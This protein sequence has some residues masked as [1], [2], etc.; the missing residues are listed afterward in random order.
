MATQETFSTVEIDFLVLA[1]R[2]QFVK[3]RMFDRSVLFW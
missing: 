2:P 3:M 1:L